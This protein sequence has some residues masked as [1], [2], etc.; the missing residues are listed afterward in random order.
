ME[1]TIR[2]AAFL[3]EALCK[4]EDKELHVFCHAQGDGRGWVQVGG[5]RFVGRN[6]VLAARR[7]HDHQT[8]S[9]KH[10]EEGKQVFELGHHVCV[11][12]AK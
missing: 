3:E 10:S 12:A 1:S 9:L 6:F 8:L 2:E 7:L 11:R 4:S 5:R